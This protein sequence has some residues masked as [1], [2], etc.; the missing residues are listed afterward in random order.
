MKKCEIP[1]NLAELMSLILSTCLD[2]K[3]EAIVWKREAEGERNLSS[4]VAR[5]HTH[6]HHSDGP[7]AYS[8]SVLVSYHTNLRTCSYE[9]YLYHGYIYWGQAERFISWILVDSFLKE[10]L[11]WV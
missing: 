10:L 8:Q 9:L 7:S 2:V 3:C 1:C 6:T 5:A 11:M 4:G